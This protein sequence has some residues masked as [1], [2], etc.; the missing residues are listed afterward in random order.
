MVPLQT[1]RRTR[2][3]SVTPQIDEFS[4]AEPN[5][6]IS[7]VLLDNGDVVSSGTGEILND[8]MMGPWV[9]EL[10][11]VLMILILSEDVLVSSSFSDSKTWW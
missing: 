9:Q 2:G 8:E 11:L 6:S 4:L 1:P 3:L 7:V 5:G 10:N